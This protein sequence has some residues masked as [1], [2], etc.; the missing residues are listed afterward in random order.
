MSRTARN[1]NVTQFFRFDQRL[2]FDQ[3]NSVG[4][5]R[6][7]AA[8]TMNFIRLTAAPGR[9]MDTGPALLLDHAGLRSALSTF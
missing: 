2:M 9:N 6:E 8:D 5:F 3:P 4:S 7:D 1:E